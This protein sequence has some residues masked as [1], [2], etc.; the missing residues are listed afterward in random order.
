M[1]PLVGIS[2]GMAC[3]AAKAAGNEIFA[4]AAMAPGIGPLS[5]SALCPA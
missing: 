3:A 4:I 5:P 1:L 2:R